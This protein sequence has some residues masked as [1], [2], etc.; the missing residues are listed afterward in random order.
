MK[1]LSVFLSQF[2]P[3]S[4][5][6]FRSTLST[7]SLYVAVFT[8]SFGDM[9][10]QS[11][12]LPKVGSSGDISSVEHVTNKRAC[13]FPNS[14]FQRCTVTP[15]D[16]R[17]SRCMSIGVQGRCFGWAFCLCV[18]TAYPLGLVYDPN[19]IWKTEPAVQPTEIWFR[20]RH[21]R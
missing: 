2:D 19:M 12:I 6:F 4:L 10:C 3:W 17:F 8:F 5:A 21:A 7:H 20:N 16:C 18:L 15:C 9:T 1:L 13:V 11:E 14:F